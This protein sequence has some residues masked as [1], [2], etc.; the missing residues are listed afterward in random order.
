MA[1]YKSPGVYGREIDISQFV[2]ALA[3]SGGAIVGASDRGPVG[4]RTLITSAKDMD[5]IFGKPNVA[6]S[7]MH[8][9]AKLFLRESTSLIVVRVA[10]GALTGG[11]FVNAGT[12]APNVQAVGTGDGTL[13]TFTATLQ[14]NLVPGSVSGTVGGTVAFKDNANGSII[15][16]AGGPALTGT[17]NYLTGALSITFTAAP[18]NAAAIAA[19]TTRYND[20]RSTA[21]TA[22]VAE[23]AVPTFPGATQAFAI[24]AINPGTWNNKLKIT[25]TNLDHDE[26]TFDINVFETRNNVDYIMETINVSRQ[27]KLDGY[28]KQLYLEDR[29]AANSRYIRVIDNDAVANTVMPAPILTPVSMSFGSDGSA[30]GDAQL[31]AGW[32]LFN[33]VDEV[34]V[35]LL[36]N[37]GYSTYA[38][39]AK[40]VEIAETR[41]D[42]FAILDVPT[43]S[44]E[45]AAALTWRLSDG[46][47]NTSFAACYTPDVEI[48]DE[49][50]DLIVNIPPSGHVAAAFARTDRISNPWEAPAGVNRA[51]V[52]ARRL[53]KAYSQAA[54]DILYPKGINPIRNIP[55]AGI[56]IW[57]QRTMQAKASA[58]DRINVRRLLITLEKSVM[59]SLIYRNFEKNTAFTR[60]QAFQSVDSFMRQ[61]QAGGGVY[62]YQ[63]VCDE[64]NNTNEVIDNNQMNIDVY[65]QPTKTAEVIQ[66]QTII[67]RTGASFAELIATGGNF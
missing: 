22:G 42:C 3:G 63:V 64:T 39:Q 11:L 7:Y 28:G 35:A 2:P 20:V 14:T 15:P 61:V 1:G 41:R 37:G 60:L 30:V 29:V 66:L 12:A 46:N 53:T 5:E 55:N 52:A 23:G 4:V 38:V 48:Y 27:R 54:R 9:H 17:I 56:A 50:N 10:N 33:N 43:A 36:I 67:T 13:K 18:A 57:G 16:V 31:V 26:N 24:M 34:D 8:Y 45:P 32:E 47:F 59:T 62:S 44:Q 49:S 19:T 40:M 25:L 58:T 65:I 51:L 21:F 6:T